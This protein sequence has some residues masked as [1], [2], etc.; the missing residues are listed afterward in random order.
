[1]NKIIRKHFLVGVGVISI[2]IG[3]ISLSLLPSLAS[4]WHIGGSW[5]NLF[6][7][8]GSPFSN[9]NSYGGVNY[10]QN[11]TATPDLVASCVANTN[12]A[13]LGQTV[14]W[15]VW[16]LGGNGVYT[17]AWNGTDGLAGSSPFVNK[18]YY[19]T[20]SKS[21][22][23]Y[24]TSDGHTLSLDCG[25]TANIY[26]NYGGTDY[27]YPGNLAVSCSADAVRA[28]MGTTIRWSAVVSGGTGNYSYYWNGTDNL[29]GASAIASQTYNNF[30]IKR[31]SVTVVSGNQVVNQ[32]CDSVV[33]VTDL[34]NNYY[35]NGYNTY[36]YYNN[37][38]GA[39][40]FTV[41][42]VANKS[43]LY[44]GEDV[45]WTANVMTPTGYNYANYLF[46]WSGTD[47]LSGSAGS[48]TKT[49]W[50]AGTKTASVTVTALGQTV[51][52]VCANSPTVLNRNITVAENNYSN[53]NTV[54]DYPPVVAAPVVRVVTATAPTT[55]LFVT[56]APSSQNIGVGQSL[57]WLANV[58]GGIGSYAYS[59]NGSDG[60][61]GSDNVLPKQYV[62]AG[63]KVAAVS[64][65]S[66]GEVAV[67]TCDL[68][69]VG[70]TAEEK[71]NNSNFNLG[72]S[73]LFSNVFIQALFVLL[74]VAVIVLALL[75]YFARF[76]SRRNS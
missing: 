75:Y 76:G 15:S 3:L 64:V 12:Q 53:T 60:L 7:Q 28:L 32:L 36:P 57:F 45:T 26:N 19:T 20:G 51:S 48:A 37:Y 47:S 58:S 73:I 31:A 50:Y 22:N 43:T 71:N 11:S 72:A 23:V 25:N 52:Q 16:V 68:A 6:I 1:M 30:G 69:V 70:I 46:S 38:Y 63:T 34:N 4:A 74:L 40:P 8:G 21:A 18:I 14:V 65:K 33:T 39:N 17:Y 49:Y 24:I 56:C 44:S 10:A 27:T 42:C 55:P 5:E 54:G 61:M 29:T 13:N 2:F 35:Y 66:G 59:W 62:T 41:S 67:T 9:N